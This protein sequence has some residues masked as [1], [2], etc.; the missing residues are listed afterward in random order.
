MGLWVERRESGIHEN[1]QSLF[2]WECFLGE[3]VLGGKSEL[4]QALPKSL[5]FV[6]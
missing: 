4:T 1:T 5:S 3:M 6:W 2:Q